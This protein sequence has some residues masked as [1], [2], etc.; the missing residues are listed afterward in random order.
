MK[1]WHRVTFGHADAADPILD[2]IG[3]KYDI[4][5]LPGGHHLTHLTLAED[6]A[7]WPRVADLI[8][9]KQA[10]DLC[11]TTFTD[12]EILAAEWVRL[13]ALHQWGYPQPEKGMAW[14]YVTWQGHC[15]KC[16]AGYRQAAPF[17]IAREPRM[18]RNHFFGF[19]WAWTA[20]CTLDVVATLATASLRGYDTWDVVLHKTGGSSA[21]VRQ[22]VPKAVAQPGL[23]EADRRSPETCATC[24]IT[25]YAYHNRGTMHLRRDALD[26]DADFLLTDEWF[27]SG[28]HS[29]YREMLV[30]QRVARIVVGERW[31]GMALK[32]IAL[33]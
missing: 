28:G 11:D 33:S 14:R 24:G 20:F 19:F 9:E 10:L 22:L 8:R 23:A 26:G 3:V 4:S 17:R 25:K 12:D 15:D 27:G 5:P 16:G 6:D 13:T 32:P 30:S 1:I 31:R 21:L 2:R 29:G 7:S 18:G